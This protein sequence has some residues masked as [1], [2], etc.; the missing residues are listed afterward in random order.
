MFSFFLSLLTAMSLSIVKTVIFWL[1]FIYLS[2]KN[3][4]DQTRKSFCTKLGPH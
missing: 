1:K 4:L 2:K 3:A